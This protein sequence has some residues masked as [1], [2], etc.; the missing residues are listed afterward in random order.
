MDRK[1]YDYVKEFRGV[2]IPAIYKHFKGKYYATMFISIPKSMDSIRDMCKEN[3]IE[4]PIRSMFMS[5]NFT[6][7][8]NQISLLN[9]NNIICHLE[10]QC[11]SPLVIYKSLY[12][13]SGAYARP[14]NMFLSEVDK[15]KYPNVEQ[16]YRFEVIK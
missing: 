3:E 12:D 6:E 8:N 16:Q 14:I 1:K 13:N 2:E 9:I 5:A 4:D 15:D 7:G 11:D 10:E